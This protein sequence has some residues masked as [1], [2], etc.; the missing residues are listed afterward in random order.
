[1][2]NYLATFTIISATMLLFS[3]SGGETTDDT[4]NPTT[5]SDN[6]H[7]AFKTPDWERNIDC[8]L[9]DLT[10]TV[11]NDSTYGVS[12]TSASTKETFCFTYPK[13]SSKIV[14]P[15]YL[16]KHKVMSIYDNN[17]P[18]QFSQKLPLNENSLDDLS[19]KL[20]SSEGFSATE[21]NQVI[22]VKYLSSEA[23]YDVFRVKCKYEMKMYLP[24]TP[25]VIKPVSGTFTFKI[26]ALKG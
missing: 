5:V 19:K 18:F 10:P 17:V 3:C 13:Y 23:N 14:N 21:Y 20:V 1:M 24:A 22:E 2:K 12:A 26:R 6:L 15:K 11:Y 9:L 8:T 7:L 4:T 16:K 25:D